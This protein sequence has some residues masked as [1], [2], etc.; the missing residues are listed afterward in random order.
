MHS[1]PNQVAS[2][3]RR[4]PSD[5]TLSEAAERWLRGICDGSIRNRSGDVFKPSTIRGYEE[6]LRL[7]VLPALGSFRLA[8]L[9]R[10]D[11]QDF[12]DELVADGHDPSTIRNTVMPLRTIMR[13]ALARGEI[14][15]NPTTGIEIPAVRGR[16]DRI[17]TPSEA[18][19]LI[20]ALPRGDKAVWATA[21]YAGLRRGELMALQWSDVDFDTGVNRVQRSWDVRE[22][23]IEPKTRAGSRNVPL[24]SVLRKHLLDDKC[25]CA[26]V[27]GLALGRSPVKPFEPSMLGWRAR[28]AWA[29]WNQGERA[30]ALADRREPSLLE[31]M[32]LHEARHT[33]ASLM[34]A[35]GVGAKAL[36]TY[37]GHASVV[38]TLD[39]Y[40]HLMP[41]NEREAADLL[42]AY[43]A[44]SIGY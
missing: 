24:A 37:M 11:V 8:E 6:A 7:R 41:G 23:V 12:V 38:I 40:G 16:R 19:T 9:D 20:A 33:F 39:R 21:V 44:R 42:D 2:R 30:S 17:A 1:K 32:T 43:L 31:P 13:R 25:H 28:R 15:V 5:C 22:G 35:A 36:S 4:A 14:G 10:F 27:E 18:A 26:W 29:A 34:I 3:I